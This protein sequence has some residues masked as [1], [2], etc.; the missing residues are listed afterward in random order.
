MKLLVTALLVLLPIAPAIAA[1]PASEAS[2][3]E[4]LVTTESGKLL[5]GMYDQL[6]KLMQGAMQ[7]A[8]GGQQLSPEQQKILEEMR[9]KVTRLYRE[10]MS[11]SVFEPM[12]VEI[13]RNTFSESEVQSMIAFYK[14]E[15]GKAVIAKMPTVLQQSMLAAQKRMGPLLPRIRQI[16]QETIEKLRAACTKDC[17]N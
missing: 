11:W 9:Q 13:Y 7:Q 6:D 8:M 10:E 14:S 16:Q 12:L 5:D 4:L 1:E 2:I 15:G 17:A 3:R